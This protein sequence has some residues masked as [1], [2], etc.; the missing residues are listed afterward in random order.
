[1]DLALKLLEIIINFLWFVESCMEDIDEIIGDPGII[2]QIDEC[3]VGR[4]GG[5]EGNLH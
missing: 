1:M 2:A 3:M 4:E 5:R